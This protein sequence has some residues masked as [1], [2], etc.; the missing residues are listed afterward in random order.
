MIKILYIMNAIGQIFIMDLFLGNNFHLYGIEA[1]NLWARGEDIGESTRFPRV[2]MCD[3]KVRLL[4]N[5][6]RHTVQCVLPINLFHENVYLIVWFWMV[7]VVLYSV[8]SLVMWIGQSAFRIDR[9]RFIK[10]NL[11][12]EIREELKKNKQELYDFVTKYLGPDGVF[13]LRLIQANTDFIVTQDITTSLFEN[14][15]KVQRG[16]PLDEP[17]ETTC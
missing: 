13:V 6:Q 9:H 11:M 17:G 7:F 1:L 5:I 8:Y 3:F 15:Q 4:G 10:K 12:P 14:F 16:L 2:T